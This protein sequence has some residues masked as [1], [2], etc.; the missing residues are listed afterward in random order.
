MHMSRHRDIAALDTISVGTAAS[1][2]TAAALA[3]T[4]LVAVA[5]STIVRWGIAVCYL[6]R[7]ARRVELDDCL[8]RRHI[9][10]R[11]GRKARI[12]GCPELFFVGEVDLVEPPA[13]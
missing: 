6:H 9:L 10:D 1:G 7:D 4:A 8:V 3:L 2:S 12:L 5:T 11:L 13:G